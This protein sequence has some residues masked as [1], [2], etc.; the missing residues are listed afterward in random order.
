MKQRNVTEIL[1]DSLNDNCSQV[2][3]GEHSSIQGDVRFQLIIDTSFDESLARLLFVFNI[4]ERSST[5]VFV[6]SSLPADIHG[7]VCLC[8]ETSTIAYI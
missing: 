3:A 1:A 7:A 4:L 6:C 8:R 2:L 5:K